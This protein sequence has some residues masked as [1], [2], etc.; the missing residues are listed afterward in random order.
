MKI[1]FWDARLMNAANVLTIGTGLAY[2]WAKYFAAAANPYSTVST[3]E[4]PTHVLHILV[5]PLLVFACGYIWRSHIAPM[6]RKLGS[7]TKT[8][9]V[10]GLALVVVLVP[11]IA[12]GYLIQV[13]VDENW[14]KAWVVVHLVTSAAWALSYIAHQKVLLTFWLRSAS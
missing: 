3:W 4:P 9:A 1:R 6:L 7:Q 10:S 5:V 11:M 14:R 13:T 8:K 2:A 12:T